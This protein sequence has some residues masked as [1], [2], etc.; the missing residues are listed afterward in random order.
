M[1]KEIAIAIVLTELGHIWLDL[2]GIRLKKTLAK[3]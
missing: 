3:N 1:I 2:R